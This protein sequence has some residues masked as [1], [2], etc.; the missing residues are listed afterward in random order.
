VSIRVVQGEACLGFSCPGIDPSSS[1]SSGA[2]CTVCPPG[3]PGAPGPQGPPGA[4]GSLW[5][6]VDDYGA[7]RNPAVD[8]TAAF[9][10]ALN[11]AASGSV[12]T[13]WVLVPNVDV[14]GGEGYGIYGTVTIPAGVVL[15]GPDG[16]DG[17]AS[18][19]YTFV[20]ANVAVF[21]FAAGL[22]RSGIEGLQILGPS[23]APSGRAVSFVGSQFN[24]AKNLQI[25][26]HAIGIDLS[27]GVTPFSAYNV[28]EQCEI[29]VCTS[30]G[31]RAFQQANANAIIGGRI[32]FTRNAGNTAVALGVSNARAL[33]ITGG[34]ALEDYNIGLQIGGAPSFSMTGCWFEKGAT[35]PLGSDFQ[36]LSTFEESPLFEGGI[37]FAGNHHAD[38]WPLAN[39]F[40]DAALYGVLPDGND[41]SA[42]L[43]H[44]LDDAATGNIRLVLLPAG[45]IVLGSTVQYHDNIALKGQGAQA[46]VLD[47]TGAGWALEQSTP[48]VRIFNCCFIGFQINFDAIADGAL[49][50]DDVSLAHLEDVV[51]IGPG[52]GVGNG[53]GFR[54]SSVINGGAVYN[55]FYHCRALSCENGFDVLP[56]GSNDTHLIDCRATACTRGVYV[57]DSNHVVIDDCAIESGTRGVVIDASISAVS[58]SLT[59]SNTRFE[60]NTVANIQFGEVFAAANVRYPNIHN[61]HHV[62]G[63]PIVGSPSFP[64]FVG[65]TGGTSAS[66]RIVT[67]FLDVPF[68]FERTVGAPGGEVMAHFVDSNAALG[69]PVSVQ[70][71]TERVAPQLRGVRASVTRWEMSSDGSASFTGTVSVT[72]AGGVQTTALAATG[73]VSF[74]TAGQSI[75]HGDGVS[76]GN[77]TEEI[78]KAAANN[79]VHQVFRNGTAAAGLRWLKIFL[80]NTNVR[81][82]RYDVNGANPVTFEL[83]DWTSIIKRLR[84][85]AADQGTA[86]TSAAFAPTG[87]GG[88]GAAIAVSTG[89]TDQ[90]GEVTFT[91][92]A[93]PAANPSFVFTFV[94][95]AWPTANPYGSV[96][97]SGGT[98]FVAGTVTRFTRTRNQTTLTVT[99]VGTPIAGETYSIE[100]NLMG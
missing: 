22:N 89:S 61:N 6:S 75:F 79:F 60:G 50:L 35:L 18:L 5:I 99:F 32:F 58:D 23:G 1:T 17:T 44:A 55:A 95:G 59:V 3:A 77:V 68:Y 88:A 49:H 70:I 16:A 63:T 42:E 28:I 93:A 90:R 73:N 36:V 69:T 82:D 4:P 38:P 67:P 86:V 15:F 25:W 78:R 43:Q 96:Q 54:M 51:T 27:D 64:T 10:A 57:L 92:G 83:D 97:F 20:G 48:G 46:T 29:N 13:T 80:S 45:T 2:S 84:R 34:L 37:L 62:T 12:G 41:H 100:W 87:F 31:I 98:G 7:S 40:I 39:G 71:T 85:I 19:I 30:F 11:A 66:I 53:S 14:A 56:Q 9:Q 52:I 91:V 81:T 24:Y 72:G 65:D 47:F 8:S 21:Q 94:D 26:Y 76:A 33:S 74:I